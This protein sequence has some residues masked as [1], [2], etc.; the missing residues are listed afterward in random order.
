MKKINNIFLIALFSVA[1][2]FVACDNEEE[3]ISFT[4]GSNL[5]ISGS[6]NFLTYESGTF[7]VE[8]FTIDETYSWSVTGDG[9][10]T[11]QEVPGREGEF[12]S[13]LAEDPGTYTISVS[14]DNNLE[15]SLSFTIETVNEFLGVGIDTLDLLENQYNAGGDTLFLPIQIS[16]RNVFETTAEFNIVE[17]SAQQGVDFEVLNESNVLTFEEGETEAF[18]L[19][20]LINREGAEGTRDFTI[21][22]GDILTTGPK[23]AAVEQAPDSL[24]VSQSVIN[25]NDDIKTVNLMIESDSLGTNSSGN[26]SLDVNLSSAISED[27]TITYTVLNENNLPILGADKTGGTLEIFAGETSAQI[28]LDI[29]EA[30]V[31]EGAEPTTLFVELTGL[32]SGN[33]EVQ[34]GTSNSVSVTAAPVA[35]D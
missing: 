29:D 7:N 33:P 18:V 8:G 35:A 27:V 1:F 17:G 10:A 19:I 28:V 11:V 15:G 3:Q 16:E 20:Q 34:L 23:S 24:Q 30:W 14:N 22:L 26:Y 2:T 32:I 13:V 6:D 12:V 21:E 9:T 4:P 31:A 25:I 5:L